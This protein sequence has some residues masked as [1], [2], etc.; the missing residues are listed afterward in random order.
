MNWV[1]WQRWHRRFGISVALIVILLVVT[2]IL[3]N[4]TSELGLAEQNVSNEFLLDW[5]EIQPQQQPVSFQPGNH[6]IT[7]IDERLYFDK[8]EVADR[9]NQLHGA[10][11]TNEL[12]VVGVDTR[13]LLFTLDG[14]LIEQL[15]GVDGVPSGMRQLG[16][17]ADNNV[18]VRAA[19]GD[20]RLDLQ[21]V[22]WEEEPE[23]AAQ[24]SEPVTLAEELHVSL[25][26]QYRG[27]GLTLER[28]ML[29]LHSGRILGSW[30]VW[31][32]DAAAILM[33]LLAITG[34]WMWLRP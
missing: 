28:V 3:L 27:K 14:Q 16:I 19:H 2:G 8:E 11:T 13:L 34:S 31:L 6:S 24:W 4:H 33:L 5:Y 22:S 1:F 23:I 32:I 10:V 7:Q 25:F 29:D 26:E 18:I 21:Q 9:I 17:D 15:A 30:G 20:Y 12:I